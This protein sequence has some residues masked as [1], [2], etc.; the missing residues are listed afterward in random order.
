MKK[1]AAFALCVVAATA[2]ATVTASEKKEEVIPA[3]GE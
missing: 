1:I 2:G 3:K